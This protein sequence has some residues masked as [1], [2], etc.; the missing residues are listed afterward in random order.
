MILSNEGIQ[1]LVAAGAIE[2]SPAPEPHQYQTSSVDLYLGNQFTGWD[3]RILGVKGA[4]VELDLAE[5]NYQTTARAYSVSLDLEKDGCFI[6]P[7]Y[8]VKP[9][10]ILA[11]TRERIFL[12]PESKLAARVEGRSSL[13]RLGVVVHLTAPVI[14]AGFNGH[15][16]LE[17]INYGPF[18]L[19]LVPEK[20]KICQLV[21]EFLESDPLGETTSQFQGQTDPTGLKK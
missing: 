20:T 5:Q 4:K 19:K 2:I 3:P 14:H 13:A 1:R 9:S 21:F 16:T 8:S 18:Y 7:P 17:M 10:H 12:K 11:T 6:F 15:I